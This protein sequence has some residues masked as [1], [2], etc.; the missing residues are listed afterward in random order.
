MGDGID[1]EFGIDIY[2]L[3]YFNNQ[4]GPTNARNSTQHLVL[5]Q[6]GK[7]FEKY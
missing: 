6:M 2:S 7:Q 5:I 4:Q 1:S 3:L